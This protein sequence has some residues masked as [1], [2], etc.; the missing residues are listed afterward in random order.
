MPAIII[1]KRSNPS[2]AKEGKYRC[3]EKHKNTQGNQSKVEIPAE[4]FFK[5]IPIRAKGKTAHT[6][7][8]VTNS[9]HASGA[10]KGF[11][12]LKLARMAPSGTNNIPTT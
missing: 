1:E 5:G 7:I 6:A 4:R 2:P 9:P 8:K 11:I 3:P 12:T 10:K